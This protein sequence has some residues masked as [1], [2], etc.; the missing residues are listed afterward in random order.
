MSKV[1]LSLV[2]SRELQSS[3]S[4]S[5]PVPAPEVAGQGRTRSTV[6][7]PTDLGEG[8]ETQRLGGLQSVE[9]C[10]NITSEFVSVLKDD[11]RVLV[12]TLL[13]NPWV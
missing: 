4:F 13:Y 8:K 6:Q 11:L 9:F 5:P 10:G 1:P 7:E 2:E 3:I 12:Y